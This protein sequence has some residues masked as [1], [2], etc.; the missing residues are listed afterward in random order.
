MVERKSEKIE[1]E[2]VIPL[3]EKCRPVPRY[4]KT[5][6]AIKSMREFLVRHMKIRDG[7]LKKI[8][9]DKSLNEI[10]WGRGIKNPPHKIKVKAVK[11]GENVIV[12]AVD[13]PQK[14]KF[15]KLREEKREQK[16]K[17]FA[18][19][20]KTMMQKAQAAATKPSKTKTPIKAEELVNKKELAE[21]IKE[22][23]EEKKKT[24]AKKVV[25]KKTAPKKKV[26][27]KKK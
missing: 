7:D 1:R 27:A 20:K 6:K 8:K 26:V 18:E 15:K 4:K 12:T 22:K 11:D 10:V 9:I 25:A 24:V 23:V 19:N 5:N 21:K 3:R 17:D 2:Y 14:I 16:A 13:V